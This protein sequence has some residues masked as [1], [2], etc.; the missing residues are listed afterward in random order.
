MKQILF[1]TLITLCILPT[2]NSQNVATDKA[3]P[4]SLPINSVSFDT[5][6]KYTYSMLAALVPAQEFPDTIIVDY[7][8]E[9][10]EYSFR[11][12]I[13]LSEDASV[14]V[15]HGTDVVASATLSVSSW[16]MGGPIY[17][18]LNA[19]FDKPTLL[20]L[21]ERY[22]LCLKEGSIHQKGDA[23][24][25][26]YE[27]SQR[28]IIPRDL[29]EAYPSIK[30]GD[31]IVS[32]NNLNFSFCHETEEGKSGIVDLYRENDLINSFTGTSSWD[33]NLGT[34]Y[35]N[36]DSKITF[37]KDVQYTFV[38][39]A[40]TVHGLYRSDLVNRETTVSFKGGYTGNS[41]VED[42]AGKEVQINVN[43]G[44]LHVYG[45]TAGT[46]VSVHT[47]DGRLLLTTVADIEGNASATL[48]RGIYIVAVDGECHK[49]IAK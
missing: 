3:L 35:F 27:I 38:L 31:T 47:A 43:S 32:L 49:I 13:E 12:E 10:F 18:F 20:D 41:G 7:P 14:A 48:E 15:Y 25:T 24:I 4:H 33:W 21:G 8:L 46:A 5:D 39:R 44:E 30:N 34:V 40:G 29:G 42:I 19:Y 28:L 26:N 9:V 17:G 6:G 45:A 37:D 1:L 11:G 2:V 23:S 16:T 36:F 22:V